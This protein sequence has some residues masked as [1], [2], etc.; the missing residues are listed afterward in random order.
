MI[1]IVKYLNTSPHQ[2]NGDHGFTME[3]LQTNPDI[4]V[5]FRWASRKMCITGRD[6]ISLQDIMNHHELPWGLEKIPKK[7]NLTYSDVI[8]NYDFFNKNILWQ[9]F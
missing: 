9:Y 6:T 2:K 3:I 7:S 5:E 1:Y 8:E 4:P